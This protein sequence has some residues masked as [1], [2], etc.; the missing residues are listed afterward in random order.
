[1]EG[2]ALQET[3]TPDESGFNV[4][5]LD[6]STRKQQVTHF[7]WQEDLY[8]SGSAVPEWEDYQVNRLR[9]KS[10]FDISEEMLEKLDDPGVV[11]T[12]EHKGRVTL[13]DV[14]VYPDLREVTH[15]MRETAHTLRG[16][17][18]LSWR[19]RPE[20]LLITGTE[21]S[22]K[23]CL[24]K[25]LYKDFH[26]K[27]FVPVL[28]DGVT[29][30]SISDAKLRRLIEREFGEQYRQDA[31]ERYRQLDRSQRVLLLDNYDRVPL[32]SSQLPKLIRLLSSYAGHLILLANDLAHQVSEVV[33]ALD[34]QDASLKI[35]HYRILPYGH[36]RREELAER[37]FAL[38]PDVI[39]DQEGFARKL[40]EA[41]RMTDTAIG[42]NFVP[43]FPV[44]LL[45]I[46]QAQDHGQP[47]NLGASTYGYFYELLIRAALAT[48]STKEDF[49]VKL[50]FLGHCAYA[51][52]EKGVTRISEQDLRAL[53]VQYE[54]S[55]ALQL[56]FSRLE[57]DL[58][59]AR[60]FER[61]G[62]SYQ[63]KYKYIY[64]YFVARYLGDRISEETVQEKVSALTDRLHEEEAANILLFLTH[65]SK[66]PLIIERMLHQ[67]AKVFEGNSREELQR[68]RMP[69]AAI[70]ESLRTLTYKDAGFRDG[71]REMLRRMD[72]S[73][74]VIDGQEHGGEKSKEDVDL[75]GELEE[76]QRYVQHVGV[77]FKTIQIL[78][79]I[80]K[81]FPGSL[82]AEL[83]ERLIR[84][85]Y[86]VGLRT[87]GSLFDSLR[88]RT[89]DFIQYAVR[90]L[91]SHHPELGEEQLIRRARESIFGLAFLA[92]YS[93][94]RRISYAVGSPTL[95]PVYDRV[96]MGD[97]TPAVD[98][99]TSALH[100]EQS[101][102]FPEAEVREL[103]EAFM[104]N[105]LADTVL[106]WMVVTHFHLFNVP[107][108]IKQ[109]VC[110][111]LNISYQRV[112]LA[113]PRLRLLPGK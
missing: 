54:H 53:L 73:D 28:L 76:A 38:S 108:D 56:S 19:P 90:S 43:S 70:E 6:T 2:A 60:V 11:L 72:E 89:D 57:A 66:H 102:P 93:M 51:M 78:G 67:A 71:R 29:V 111:R 49:D 25:R 12:H 4:I 82:D 52:F 39:D 1:L 86:G 104:Q 99:I 20:R 3:G 105:P 106:R 8:V 18:I 26:E 37:W 112:Q 103:H 23:T 92:S 64:Y 80:L 81:N 65:I 35:G 48:R 15:R 32:R 17:S 58:L 83:K 27:G 75:D 41:K 21:K 42:H 40:V 87:L 10:G 97:A 110:D 36:V 5:V 7:E 33:G 61:H 62:D 84:E 94:I 77:A 100:L 13:S 34:N 95:L 79:Q 59:K 113:D 109:R 47:V 88:E 9:L 31:L 68:G 24:A 63:F 45:P 55:Y 44:F 74:E 14:F 16:E 22:G 98:L 46:L 69:F 96:R 101:A 107:Y 50:A 30:D 85:C 91:R